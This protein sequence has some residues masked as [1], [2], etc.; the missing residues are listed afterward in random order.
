L[1]RTISWASLL[2]VAVTATAFAWYVPH[3]RDA[4]MAIYGDFRTNLPWSMI[5][6]RA[7]PSGVIETVAALAV[8]IAAVVQVRARSKQSATLF[9]LLVV[10]VFGLT[11][12]AYREAMGSG[13][14]TLIQSVSGA[15]A[16]K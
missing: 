5:V 15:A 6:I 10:V 3:N 11:F 8:L 4:Q 7:I 14:E 12:L 2:V 13:M 9:H 16:G 1:D